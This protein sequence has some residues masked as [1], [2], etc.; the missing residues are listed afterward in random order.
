MAKSAKSRP[1]ELKD[2]LYSYQDISEV[3]RQA[4]KNI[5]SQGRAPIPPIYEEEFFNQAQ[6]LGL[7]D[8][9]ERLMARI[10]AGQVATI[11]VHSL[12]KMVHRI[13]GDLESFG[14]DLDS[15]TTALKEGRGRLFDKNGSSLETIKV[16]LDEILK[17]N[18]KMSVQLEETRKQLRERE[19]QVNKLKQ[20]TRV[21]TLTGALNRG[22]MEED[23]P[24]E[25]ARS[26]RYQRPFSIVMA[27]IDHFKKI[28]DTY[29]H[30]IGDE[31]L[32]SFSRL[33]MSQIRDVD[34]L[35][36]YGG[37]EFLILLRDT[38]F[39]GACIAAERIRETI[40]RHILRRKDDPSIQIR[41]TSS[42]GVSSWKESDCSYSEVVDRADKALYYAKESGR[43]Q[44]ASSE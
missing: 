8:L 4:L 16:A 14:K 39:E 24:L 11:L 9:V 10:P 17:A 29:G 13:D 38:S 33:I 23:L 19:K 22:A 21:D 34:G 25:F 20:R 1:L 37:E 18:L 7:N 30:A 6:A 5:V 12:E 15:H 27:D 26:R 41:I 28:N 42:F 2:C 31:V 32:K 3:A 44:V 35:Y 43:N 36:R 40:E